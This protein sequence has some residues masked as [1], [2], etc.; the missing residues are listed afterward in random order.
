MSARADNDILVLGADPYVLRACAQYELRPVVIYPPWFEHFGLFELPP[1]AIG[2]LVEDPRNPDDVLR[3]LHRRGLADRPYRCVYTSEENGLVTAAVVAQILGARSIS[4]ST[5]VRCRD[6]AVQKQAVRQSGVPVADGIVI[7]DVHDLTSLPPLPYE[8]AVLKPVGGTAV[9]QT[10]RIASQDDLVATARRIVA[11]RGPN[12]TFLLEEFVPGEEWVVDGVVFGGEL[13]L[14][15]LGRYSMPPLSMLETGT[16]PIMFKFDP[17]SDADRYAAAAPIVA[18]ALAALG[19]TDGVFHME[20][21]YDPRDGQLVYGECAARRGGGL[22]QEVVHRKFGVDLGAAAVAC[23]IGE[24]P[25]LRTTISPDSVGCVYL[26]VRPGVLVSCPSVADLQQLPGVDYARLELPLGYRSA[27]SAGNTVE[28]I[29]QV[30]VSGTSDAEVESRCQE[31]ERW[32]ADST[33]LVPDG[34]APRQLREWQRTTYPEVDFSV[35][36]FGA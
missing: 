23:A 19:L 17:S 32:F 30:M 20:L 34:V 13:V 7:D 12:R 35:R 28:R 21:F 2:L 15:T 31:V 8:H 25:D 27:G 4:P 22:I 6:K 11:E 36:L 16:A 5:A 33:V 3:A 14:L 1:D 26:P 24:P 29:G 9:R 10:F 18:K